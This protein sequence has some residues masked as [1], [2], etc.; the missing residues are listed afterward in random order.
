VTCFLPAFVLLG[1]VPVV[2]GIAEQ[3]LGGLR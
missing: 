2:V 3:V 1:V